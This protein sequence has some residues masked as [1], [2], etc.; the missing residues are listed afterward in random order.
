[1]LSRAM[2]LNSSTLSPCPSHFSPCSLPSLLGTSDRRTHPFRPIQPPNASPD[3][4]CRS[5]PSSTPHTSRRALPHAP[6][7]W[8]RAAM[9]MARSMHAARASPRA[10]RRS[11]RSTDRGVRRRSGGTRSNASSE[12]SPAAKPH[13]GSLASW[14]IALLA[15][16]APLALL[17]SYSPHSPH[18][19]HAP[20][21]P[22]LSS[23]VDRA[24][25]DQQQLEPQ[26][27]AALVR[28]P[29]RQALCYC[30]RHREAAG[31]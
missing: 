14:L 20:S 4:L 8:A 7:E 5:D 15:C 10:Y 13:N 2:L 16:S 1:M 18:V 17:S 19:T 31:G 30:P 12:L 28:L 26:P 29:I 3:G 25:A 23:Q 27:C 22:G 9:P 6:P 21:P 11:R 24:R